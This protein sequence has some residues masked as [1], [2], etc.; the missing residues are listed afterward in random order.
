MGE[1]EIV[2]Q[3]EVTDEQ[4]VYLC[5]FC[6]RSSDEFDEDFNDVYTNPEI[7]R[8]NFFG[9]RKDKRD[10]DSDSVRFMLSGWRSGMDI[11]VMNEEKRH[12]CDECHNAHVEVHN[13][14]N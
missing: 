4:E 2:E 6:G 12:Y 3:V 11:N 1:R 13:D 14:D 8:P 9:Y 7:E 10:T 5:D